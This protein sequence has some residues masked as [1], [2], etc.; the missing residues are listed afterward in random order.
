MLTFDHDSHRYWWNGD[1][2]PSVTQVL[3]IL[4]DFEMVEKFNPGAVA[5]ASV[6]GDAVHYACELY[7]KGT[8]DWSTLDDELKP[9]LDAWILFRKQTGFIPNRI[10]HKVFHPNLRYAGTLDRTGIL[11]DNHVV[12]D[13]K[14][15]AA[16]YPTTGPQLAAYEAAIKATEPNGPA[17]YGRYSVQLHPDGKYKLHHYEN[18]ADLS[19]FISSLTLLN[20]ANT[21]KQ[22]IS[23]E[24]A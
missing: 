11:F 21:N 19:V 4:T 12:I 20:W 7:D 10:E 1:P 6:R 14:A 18:R 15:V 16:I 17:S 8:L 2:V 13:I 23:Y 22:R 5:Y 3:S 24:P 9:Y